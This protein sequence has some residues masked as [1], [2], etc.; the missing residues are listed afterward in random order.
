M[1]TPP[2]GMSTMLLSV[3]SHM[4]TIQ[5]STSNNSLVRVLLKRASFYT[6]WEVKCGFGACC[7]CVCGWVH[8][9]SF[10]WTCTSFDIEVNVH[11]I[12]YSQDTCTVN[13]CLCVCYR[14]CSLVIVLCTIPTGSDGHVIMEERAVAASSVAVFIAQGLDVWLVLTLA[15]GSTSTTTRRSQVHMTSDFRPKDF[16]PVIIMPLMVCVCA[17]FPF[18]PHGTQIEHYPSLALPL[19][20]LVTASV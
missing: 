7:V 6:S 14:S 16:V 8:A 19:T 12:L 3:L 4:L 15:A 10:V 13:T 9:K 11:V 2:I 1:C 18:Y 20:L 17:L 5:L